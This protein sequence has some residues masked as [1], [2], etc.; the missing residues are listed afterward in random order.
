MGTI[1]PHSVTD[2]LPPVGQ[3]PFYYTSTGPPKLHQHRPPT[4]NKD[5]RA[6]GRPAKLHD[7]ASTRSGVG[8]TDITHPIS[9]S[10]IQ[11]ESAVARR[12]RPAVYSNSICRTAPIGTSVY[13]PGIV[14]V[15][16]F[17]K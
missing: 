7:L 9:T 12:P 2:S 8:P 10:A 1:V 4:I 17:A 15:E 16:P 5:D 11:R 14:G 3:P 6:A 13:L